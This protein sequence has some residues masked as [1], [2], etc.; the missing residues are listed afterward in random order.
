MKK[1]ASLLAASLFALALLSSPVAAGNQSNWMTYDWPALAS[2][3]SPAV[4]V[5]TV[6]I[7]PNAAKLPGILAS[8]WPQYEEAIAAVRSAIAKDPS[9]KAELEAKGVA[10]DKVIGITYSRNGSIAVLVNQA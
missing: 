1:I 7:A 8:A 2:S 10:P 5:V 4:N 9:L 6:P 3:S